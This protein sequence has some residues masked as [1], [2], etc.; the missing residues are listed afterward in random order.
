M[1]LALPFFV[2]LI[3]V[4]ADYFTTM[5][6]LKL[7]FYETHQQYHPAYALIIFWAP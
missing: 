7:G 6:G 5:V 4:L 1:R 2:S 3:G